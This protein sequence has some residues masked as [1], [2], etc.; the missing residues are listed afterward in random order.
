M[1]LHVPSAPDSDIWRDPR[2]AQAKSLEEHLLAAALLHSRERRVVLV[3]QCRP[4]PD[5]GI[6]LGRTNA[7]WYICL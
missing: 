4:D 1:F 7:S 3:S 5:G 2:F 6:W